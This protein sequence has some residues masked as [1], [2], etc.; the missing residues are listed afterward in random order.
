M[1]TKL[2]SWGCISRKRPHSLKGS[3]TAAEPKELS[4]EVTDT[5]ASPE[6]ILA[7]IW[8]TIFSTVQEALIICNDGSLQGCFF[9]VTIT[10]LKMYY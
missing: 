10:K 7:L 2:H 5:V 6:L 4:L 8:S 9:L 3:I 1:V